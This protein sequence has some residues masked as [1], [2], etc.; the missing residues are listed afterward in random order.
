[1]PLRPCS[2]AF[3]QGTLG[4]CVTQTRP[5]GGPEGAGHRQR[6][7]EAP[8]QLWGRFQ[9]LQPSREMGTGDGLALICA[10]LCEETES[11]IGHLACGQILMEGSSVFNSGPCCVCM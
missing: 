9:A 2:T 1:M 7:C 4:F 6:G 8:G 3:E 10:R 11:F 5:Q